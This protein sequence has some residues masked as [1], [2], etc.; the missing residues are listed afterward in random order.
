MVDHGRPLEN[1]KLTTHNEKGGYT[2][3]SIQFAMEF[4]PLLAL[5][6]FFRRRLRGRGRRCLH[7][8]WRRRRRVGCTGHA[9]LETADA[10]AEPFHDFWDALSAK[11]NQ[12]NRK[13][14]HPMKNTELTH[15]ASMR[16]NSSGHAIL[17][18]AQSLVCGKT[19]PQL[20]PIE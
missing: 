7:L 4:L 13:N 6:L 15:G 1:C 11:E 5:L 8:W 14:D 9:F 17:T 18:L 16:P 10:L 20:A 19:V 2:S 12:N 3:R